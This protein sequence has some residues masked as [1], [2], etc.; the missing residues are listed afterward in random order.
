MSNS[1]AFQIKKA[2][3][4]QFQSHNSSREPGLSIVDPNDL[5]WGKDSFAEKSRNF[6]SGGLESNH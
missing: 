3:N 6:A 2:K 4:Y 1:K 5:L